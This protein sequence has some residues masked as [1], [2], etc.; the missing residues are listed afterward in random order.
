MMMTLRFLAGMTITL[1]LLLQTSSQDDCA[2][3]PGQL[4]N[5]CAQL[6]TSTINDL[7]VEGSDNPR[8]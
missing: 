7:R 8:V 5:A 6:D 4:F 1:G 3:R 2:P